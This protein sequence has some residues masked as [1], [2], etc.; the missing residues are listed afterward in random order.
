MED[1]VG[2]LLEGSVPQIWELQFEG[3]SERSS[4]RMLAEVVDR[5]FKCVDEV[6]RGCGA[7]FG[8]VVGHRGLDVGCGEGAD[9]GLHWGVLSCRFRLGL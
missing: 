3:E 9:V 6:E 8:A 4:E 2:E 7:G 1:E 5:G